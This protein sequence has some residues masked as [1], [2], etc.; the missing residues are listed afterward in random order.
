[1]WYEKEKGKNHSE[2][3]YSLYSPSCY[4]LG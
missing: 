3:L 1:M 4:L 2:E